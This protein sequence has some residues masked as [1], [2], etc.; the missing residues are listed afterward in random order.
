M[1][2]KGTFIFFC[3]KMGAGK[4]TLSQEISSQEGAILLSEDEW[5]KAIYPDEIRTFDDYITY[6]SRLKPMMKQH[7]QHILHA[8]VSVVMDFPGNTEKQRAWLKEI[9][10]ACG[11]DHKLIYL[12]AS[13]DFCIK[14][15]AKRAKT[16]PQRALF[17]TEDVFHQV[18][19][20]F[21]LPL[22]KEGF[23]IHVVCSENVEQRG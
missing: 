19:R 4:S 14:R 22:E 20:Y 16:Q 10:T 11:C 2:T 7:V 3:G 1:K 12:K 17:D 6:S 5:L 15:I 9:Y 23:N 18:T 8:G 21:Q 13:D